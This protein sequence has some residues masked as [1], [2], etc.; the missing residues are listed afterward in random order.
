MTGHSNASSEAVFNKLKNSHAEGRLL[1]IKAR[2][3]LIKKL[4]RALDENESRIFSA[5]KADLGRPVF[6]AY[7]AEIALIKEEGRK[8]L[9]SL[10]FWAQSKRVY[11][12]LVFQPGHSFIKPSPK[13]VVLIIAPWNY[14]FQLSL[15]PLISALA[16]GNCVVVKASELA[17]HSAALI[18]EII[19]SLDPLCVESLE[20]DKD[21]A[22]ELLSLPF[23]HIFFT[24]SSEI[25]K[26]VMKLAAENLTP[27]TLELG[28]KCP[29]IIDNN[30][31]LDLAVK[32]ILWA[33]CL[34]AGQTCI[35]PDYVLLPKDK[36]NSF[37]EIAKKHL[38]KMFPDNSQKSDSYSRIIND[39]HFMRLES[40]LSDG[41]VALGGRLDRADRYIEL[42]IM[43]AI[44]PNARVMNEEIFGPILPLITYTE[45]EEAQAFVALKPCPLALY[46]FS[47]NKKNID[48]ITNK[49]QSG[50]LCINDC[51]SHVAILDL[52]FGG[53]RHSGLGNYHGKFGFDS[54][55][56]MRAVHKKLDILDNPVK[57]APYSKE[58]LALARILV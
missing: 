27:V 23:D 8:A 58:K 37:I 24:G 10:H 13:G 55:S 6:E 14:P 18:H 41:K 34:N 5:L 43:T 30:T 22:L 11:T 46:F 53:L 47:N 1:A 20:G 21:R 45:L 15:L 9:R 12:S 26:S 31:N 49:T 17:P 32:R 28:G 19:Q 40:Y 57:Y 52:P 56:H 4:L 42:S 36:E 2:K 33:K 3:E 54:F 48:I 50:A 51:M 35:A 29:V 44:K 25:G 39:R 7:V 16:A 38:E